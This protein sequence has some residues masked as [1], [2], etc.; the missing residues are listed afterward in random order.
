MA[1]IWYLNIETES[2][3]GLKPRQELELGRCIELLDLT[4]DRW[5]S[6]KDTLPALKTGDTLVDESGYVYVFMRVLG[7]EI[8]TY[9]D[10]RWKPGWYKSPLTIVGIETNRRKKPK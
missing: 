2:L 8:D 4:P 5:D 1:E 6:E 9:G 7:D 3:E 10:K